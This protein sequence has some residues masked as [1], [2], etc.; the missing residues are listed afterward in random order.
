MSA[1]QTALLVFSFHPRTHTANRKHAALTFSQGSDD[2]QRA[3]KQRK[4][5]AAM[6]ISAIASQFSTD[7]Y[8][9]NTLLIPKRGDLIPRQPF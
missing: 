9:G 7:S 3:E 8:A 2:F 5:Q 1:W 4:V 6:G